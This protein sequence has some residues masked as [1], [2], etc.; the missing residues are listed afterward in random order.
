[1]TIA[2][3]LLYLQGITEADKITSIGIVIIYPLP[4]SEARKMKP[5]SA[6]LRS[7]FSILP[8]KSRITQQ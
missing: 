1:L 8:M 5:P 4:K 6:F 2:A 7:T 3:Q